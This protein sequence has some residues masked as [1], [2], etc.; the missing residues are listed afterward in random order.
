MIGFRNNIAMQKSD[1]LEVYNFFAAAIEEQLRLVHD[2]H[3]PV[4]DVLYK[5]PDSTSIKEFDDNND[6]G[7][8]D[9]LNV[10]SFIN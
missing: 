8:N 2:I 4:G 7:E 6:E 9:G 5:K 3:L 10:M 1:R